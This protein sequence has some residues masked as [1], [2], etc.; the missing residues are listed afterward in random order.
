MDKLDNINVFFEYVTQQY[1][2][3]KQF[4]SLFGITKETAAILYSICIKKM[5]TFNHPGFLSF[6]IGQDNIQHQF[7]QASCGKRTRRRG[8]RDSL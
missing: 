7:M 2:N 1:Q 4:T 5:I 6:Y 3:E 8:E